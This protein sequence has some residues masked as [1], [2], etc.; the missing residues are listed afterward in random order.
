MVKTEILEELNDLNMDRNIR[1]S[2]LITKKGE[3]LTKVGNSHDIILEDYFATLSATVFGA[4]TESSM[5]F[6]EEGPTLVSIQ[7]KNG[8]TILRKIG[9]DHILV[10]RTKTYDDDTMKKISQICESIDQEL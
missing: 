4:S 9:D 6:V 3:I 2:Y 7:D 10:S 5:L 8:V 1:F